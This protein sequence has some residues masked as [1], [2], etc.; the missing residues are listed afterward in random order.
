[1]QDYTGKVWTFAW[2]TDA[3]QTYYPEYNS[4][5]GPETAWN[6]S[7]NFGPDVGATPG[8]LERH[9]A[10]GFCW[11][12]LGVAAA[13]LGVNTQAKPIWLAKFAG[14]PDA[15]WETY[16]AGW[17]SFVSKVVAATGRAPHT[18]NII[19]HQGEGD[20]EAALHPLYADHLAEFVADLRALHAIDTHS[21][22]TIP[23]GIVRTKDITGNPWLAAGLAAVRAAQVAV[24]AQP[25]NY[26][27]D[28]DATASRTDHVHDSGEG[29]IDVGRAI[30]A[31]LPAWYD[32]GEAA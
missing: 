3:V 8:L 27:I 18:R 32:S 25:G 9:A 16:A 11:F 15:V 12:K 19:I 29:S 26:L 24:A 10:T 6:A 13:S 21:A 17:R 4:N 7:G 22:D 28:V 23:V 20:T 31:S 1:M 30:S 5:S 2:S 14:L